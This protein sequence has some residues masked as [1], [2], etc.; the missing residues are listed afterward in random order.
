[1]IPSAVFV[2]AEALQIKFSL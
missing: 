2:P 1:M